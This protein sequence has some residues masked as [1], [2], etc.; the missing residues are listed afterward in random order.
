MQVDC[1]FIGHN[2]MDFREYE[3]N[4]RKM[5][6]YSGA[7]RD[8]NLSFIQYENKPYSASEI[9]NLFYCSDKGTGDF[10]KRKPLTMTEIFSP[11]IAY[12]GSYLHRRGMVFDY[13]NAFQEEKEELKEK[14]LEENILTIAIV[15]T[16][17]VSVFPILEIVDFIRR[18][19]STAKIIIGGPFVATRVRVQEPGVLEDLFKSIGADFYVNDAQGEATLVTIIHALKKNLPVHRINNIFYKTENGYISTPIVKENNKLSENMVLW[20]LFAHEPNTLVNIRTA[21]SCPFSCAFCGFPRHAGK[22]QTSGVDAVEEELNRL[23]KIDCVTFVQFIDDTFNV[24][25]KR[26]KEILRMMIKNAYGFKW[27]SHFRCQFADRE[28]VELMKQSGCQGAFLGIESGSEQILKMMNKAVK[29]EEYLR[30]IALLK[31]YDI[32][33]Y[34]SFILGFPG[35]TRQTVM[36]TIKFIKESQADFFRA[37]LWYCEPITP[38]WAERAKYGIKGE[39][40]EWSHNTMNSREAADLIDEIFLS[41]EEPFWVPQYSF[42]WDA[43]FQLLHRQIPLDT[44]KEFLKI[45]NKAIKEKLRNPAQKEISFETIKQLKRTCGLN[46]ADTSFEYSLDPNERKNRHRKYEAEFDF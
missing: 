40:F 2:A 31:E 36:D 32:L 7:Y 20:E 43:V 12:L 45:F 22:Y 11:A 15:T 35:E 44:I 39:S 28:T 42:E 27:H 14:L 24:P 30:G 23:K 37:Q 38:I 46:P 21:I 41:V 29:V 10:D 8:L 26:F 3:K 17:Y 6:I 9:F 18:Y 33:T 19:N 16:L 1:L 4:T 13:V 34:G 5:G 25:K